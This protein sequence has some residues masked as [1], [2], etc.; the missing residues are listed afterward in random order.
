MIEIWIRDRSPLYY[1]TPKNK[2]ILL[3]VTHTSDEDGTHTLCWDHV[4]T[5]EDAIN[6]AIELRRALGGTDDLRYI[7][8]PIPF[9]GITATEI[10]TG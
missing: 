5:M 8:S 2:I 4:P 10:C 6:Y 1:T 7:H 9:V 3:Q